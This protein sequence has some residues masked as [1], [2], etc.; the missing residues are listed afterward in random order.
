M[1]ELKLAAEK[2]A[3]LKMQTAALL[4]VAAAMLWSALEADRW[5]AGCIVA[6]I[7]FFIFAYFTSQSFDAANA[8]AVRVA[9]IKAKE[10]A[11]G[12]LKELRITSHGREWN[13]AELIVTREFDVNDSNIH[14]L[15]FDPAGAYCIVTACFSIQHKLI[16]LTLEPISAAKGAK[17]AQEGT[18]AL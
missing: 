11:R 1:S 16:R 13:G 2:L 12:M 18:P 8:Q 6:M 9:H 7:V 17:L 3:G 14:F 10:K 4:L 15:C 5:S